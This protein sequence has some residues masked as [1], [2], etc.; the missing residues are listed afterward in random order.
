VTGLTRAD[1]QVADNGVLQHVDEVFFDSPPIDVTLVLDVTRLE[2]VN[3]PGVDVMA[4]AKELRP[5]DRL[6]VIA[7]GRDVVEVLPMQ[8]VSESTRLRA[9]RATGGRSFLDG[10]AVALMRPP[11]ADRRHL[12]VSIA[13][14]LDNASV[15]DADL[16][17][18]VVRRASGVVHVVLS[19]TLPE[20]TR[21]TFGAIAALTGGRARPWRIWEQSLAGIF[22]QIFEEFRQSYVIVY[23][24]AGV[25]PGGWHELRVTVPRRGDAT[26]RARSGYFAQR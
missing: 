26:V 20:S 9:S 2:G 24:P 13:S 16:V 15:L 18:E 1:F 3:S 21:E 4:I 7:S 8:A 22:K 23:R 17:R 19:V 12:V 5:M 11:P 6:G 14:G 25:T 10:T